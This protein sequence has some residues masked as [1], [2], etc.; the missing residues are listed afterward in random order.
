M[1]VVVSVA[2]AASVEVA[3]VVVV[4]AEMMAAVVVM[5]A[6][7]IVVSSC[8][9]MMLSQPAF[10]TYSLNQASRRASPTRTQP[11]QP[12]RQRRPNAT[13]VLAFS[14]ECSRVTLG[15]VWRW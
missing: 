2:V 12:A 3:V 8:T 7:V 6:V 10:V 11:R 5:A 14:V 9:Q 13:G 15:W 1:V 4:V